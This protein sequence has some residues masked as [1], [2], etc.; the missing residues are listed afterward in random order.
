MSRRSRLRV[1]PPF[2]FFFS[3]LIDFGKYDVVSSKRPLKRALML[4]GFCGALWWFFADVPVHRKDFAF[5]TALKMADSLISAQ[6]TELLDWDALY[7]PRA[8]LTLSGD[9]APFHYFTLVTSGRCLKNVPTLRPCFLS[10]R[11]CFELTEMFRYLKTNK[12][13]KKSSI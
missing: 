9:P 11:E 1:R 2:F 5:E 3:E 8:S 4:P 7:L 13:K 12:Q 6:T 10:R